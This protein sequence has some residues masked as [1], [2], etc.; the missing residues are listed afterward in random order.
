MISFTLLT[1]TPARL[2]NALISR[3]IIEQKTDPRT[4]KTIYVGTRN[5]V[6][7]V[8]V[9]NPIVV[10]PA[11]GEPRLPDGTPNPAYV[12]PVMDTRRV[13]LVKVAHEAE[14]DEVEGL[15]QEDIDPDTGRRTRRSVLLRTKLGQWV[16]ANSTPDTITSADGRSWQ[17]R[18]INNNFWLTISD[19][20]GVWQ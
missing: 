10:T 9:P 5:G 1:D 20:F 19:D 6:E 13:Y 15:Q 17:A 12:P 8:E 4:G 11:V 14:A 18:N 16:M 3:G 7:F 2:R